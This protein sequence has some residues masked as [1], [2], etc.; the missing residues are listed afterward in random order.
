MELIALLVIAVRLLV[1]FIILRY[2]LL[3][4][5][6]AMLAD[7]TDF[8]YIGANDWYQSVDKLLDTYYLAFAAYI[9]LRWKDTI[10]RRLALGM[11]AWRVLGVV[12]TLAT[13]KEQLLVLFPNIFESWFIFYLL[14]VRLTQKKVLFDSYL[15]AAATGV[16]LLLPK[17]AH[18]YVLHVYLP[19][20]HEAPGAVAAAIEA[21]QPL[22]GMLWLLPQIAVMAWL[23]LRARPKRG[24]VARRLIDWRQA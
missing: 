5:A 6:V 4:V 14:C 1:P 22:P 3:G 23:I 20:R 8:D 19:A 9:A 15:T 16:I 17:L 13:G 7:F 2:P 21:P 18:E 10:A 12:L 24:S 11:F